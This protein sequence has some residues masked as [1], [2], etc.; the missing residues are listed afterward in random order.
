[1]KQLI[2]AWFPQKASLRTNKNNERSHAPTLFGSAGNCTWEKCMASICPSIEA[3]SQ[4]SIVANSKYS[5][6]T[7]DVWI[8]GKY[9]QI[10]KLSFI[11]PKSPPSWFSLLN[12]LPQMLPPVPCWPVL[13]RPFKLFVYRLFLGE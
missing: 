6:Q 12:V 10:N 3:A 8:A 9:R 1:M 11:Q 13:I 7:I 2:W 4:Y 5:C